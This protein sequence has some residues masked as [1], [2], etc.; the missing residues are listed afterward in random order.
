MESSGKAR[1]LIGK[2]F[3]L[4]L[5]GAVGWAA[6]AQYQSVT[7]RTLTQK[8]DDTLYVAILT[9]PAMVA[10]YNRALANP[11]GPPLNGANCLK[12]LLIMHTIYS[13]K[14]KCLLCLYDT[15]F[16]KRLNEMSFGSNSKTA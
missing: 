3:L 11:Y 5:L 12:L 4:G 6:L 9:Q 1:S 13:N 14:L 8:A 10:A 2:L 15:I 7:V 16:Q